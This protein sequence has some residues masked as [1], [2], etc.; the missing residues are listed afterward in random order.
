MIEDKKSVEKKKGFTIN[1]W[2]RYF[3]LGILICMFAFASFM[4]GVLTTCNNSDAPYIIQNSVIS[5]ACFSQEGYL[6][7]LN[8]LN[9]GKDFN[10]SN[11]NPIIQYG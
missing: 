3:L 8:K 1:V 10:S 2:L 6:I 11:I 9:L 7:Y 5:Y 4:I